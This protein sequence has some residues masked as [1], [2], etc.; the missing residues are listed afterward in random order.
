M[1][2]LLRMLVRFEE[3][4]SSQIKFIADF[5]WGCS[6]CPP[7]RYAVQR[8]LCERAQQVFGI[9]L[10]LL[11]ITSNKLYNTPLLK[12]SRS[13][14]III[15]PIFSRQQNVNTKINI[16][17]IS[18]TNHRAR[19]PLVVLA[20]QI[21]QSRGRFSPFGSWLRSKWFIRYSRCLAVGEL[22]WS[23]AN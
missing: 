13:L 21:L 9:I 16:K 1:K 12:F 17:L 10:E 11:A 8:Y 22:D 3:K 15:I 23:L 5:Q 7:R 20:S 19:F 6:F 2:Y 14:Q 18:S 4:I